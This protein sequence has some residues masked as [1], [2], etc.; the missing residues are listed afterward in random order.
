MCPEN[1]CEISGVWWPGDTWSGRPAAQGPRSPDR[2]PQVCANTYMALGS[3]DT[4][5]RPGSDPTLESTPGLET[6]IV[7]F[8][9]PSPPLWRCWRIHEFYSSPFT[10]NSRGGGGGPRSIFCLLM[11]CVEPAG[12]RTLWI[13]LKSL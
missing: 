13:N 11:L 1:W 9:T 6:N 8:V 7:A 10:L 3:I 4:Q 5:G 2:N 12:S